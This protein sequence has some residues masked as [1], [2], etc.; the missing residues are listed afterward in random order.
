[1]SK[2]LLVAAMVAVLALGASIAQATPSRLE[3][4]GQGGGGLTYLADDTNMFWNPAT[5]N[6]YPS[7]VMI[8]L[9][10]FDDNGAND[11]M[12]ATGTVV[13]GIGPL[14][15]GLGV[16]RNPDSE[17]QAISMM[18]P[19]GEALSTGMG[20]GADG[21]PGIAGVDDDGDTIVDNASEL[22]TA[23]SDDAM[24]VLF[25]NNWATGWSGVPMGGSWSVGPD[26]QPGVATV[27]D[28]GDTTV[29]DIGE[30][31]FAGS[32]D[33]YTP[34]MG[35]LP[36]GSTQWENPL[37]IIVGVKAGNINIG[38]SYYIA[39]GRQVA[40]AVTTTPGG[41]V[42]A[43]DEY[44][45]KATIQSWKLGLAMEAGS[46]SPELW[47]HYDPFTLRST[48]TDN[49]ASNFDY[50]LE[51]MLK[52]RRI[53][54]GTRI[55]FKANDNLT[56]V[57][58]F[59]YSTTSGE[60]TFD[61]SANNVAALTYIMG[62]GPASYTNITVDDL[63]ESYKATQITTGLGI[64]YVKD[65]I[66]VASSL[67]LNWMKAVQELEIDG[68]PGGQT[69]TMRLFQIPVVTLGIEYEATK[70]LVLRTG[71]STSTLHSTLRM[72]EEI[73]PVN[74]GTN[75]VNEEENEITETV[76]S[77]T[78]SAGV[79]LHFGDLVVD[80]TL[81][82]AT[83]SGEDDDDALFTRLDVKYHF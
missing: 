19:N 54:I 26:G 8:N 35:N 18:A 9:G 72:I 13:L 82:G 63:S 47:F 53:N 52:G 56:V 68:V 67:G 32:D 22:G 34:A 59:E 66:L 33:V 58:M 81:G 40:S 38:L 65:R 78:A 75:V 29:D 3:T 69:N 62:P 15:L 20:A 17:L 14:N 16:G 74:D 48:W 57:P 31:G 42:V 41:V 44:D 25:N 60:A 43:D 24:T 7:H 51:R 83:V 5:V 50:E 1:M 12:H 80:M 55:P 45:L 36:N 77:T 64:N 61:E 71:I 79:G 30:L 28:D 73:D 49:L 46:M 10:G 23:G 21:Q 70:I 11:D 76:Q 27:D 39:R 37:D 4:L 6:A 2:K